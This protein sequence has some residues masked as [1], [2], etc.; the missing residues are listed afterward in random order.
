M[1]Y[2]RRGSRVSV[3]THKVHPVLGQP[4]EALKEEQECEEG[5]EARGEVIPENGERQA[6]LSHRIPRALNEVLVVYVEN[7]A[8]GMELV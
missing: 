6:R 4:V 8:Q 5:D 3:I 2:V 1:H 7:E